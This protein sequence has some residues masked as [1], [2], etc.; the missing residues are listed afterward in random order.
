MA[1]SC[2]NIG[3]R[4]ETKESALLFLGTCLR[5]GNKLSEFIKALF[6]K[7][8]KSLHKENLHVTAGI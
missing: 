8:P 1:P 2:E 3:P 7:L 4:E 5:D 6:F